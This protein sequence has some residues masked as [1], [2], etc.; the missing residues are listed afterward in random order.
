MML[1]RIFAGANS[2]SWKAQRAP[3]IEHV[4]QQAGELSFVE[5]RIPEM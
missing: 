3:F 1:D 4:E 2:C 5:E